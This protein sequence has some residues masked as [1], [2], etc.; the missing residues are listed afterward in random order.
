[1][2]VVPRSVEFDPGAAGLAG[3]DDLS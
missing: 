1:V 3:S 2:M